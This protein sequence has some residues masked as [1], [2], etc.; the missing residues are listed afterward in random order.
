MSTEKQF[1]MV[2]KTIFGFEELAMQ[3]LKELGAANIEKGLRAVTFEGDMG[4][5][6]KANLSCR[7]VIK[8]LKPILEFSA[9]TEKSLYDGIRKIEFDALNVSA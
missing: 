7:T 5:M 8:I 1:K 9:F 4:F 6:Y 2:A 3:E